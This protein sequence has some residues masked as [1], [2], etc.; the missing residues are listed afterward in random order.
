MAEQ[1]ERSS[2][3]LANLNPMIGVVVILFA[4]IVALVINEVS[5]WASKSE[6]QS[7][8]ELIKTNHDMTMKQ[9][10]ARLDE[11]DKRF[12][13]LDSRMNELMQANNEARDTLISIKQRLDDMADPGIPY[14]PAKKKR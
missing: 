7:A 5:P 9:L 1:D 8:L 12:D 13:S 14:I 11:D 2:L 4:A 3:S 6:M 10:Q